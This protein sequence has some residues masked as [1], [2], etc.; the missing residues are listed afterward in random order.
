MQLMF[1]YNSESTRKFMDDF[2]SIVKSDYPITFIEDE[3]LLYM[4][5]K[6]EP[7]F[8]VPAKKTFGN[9]EYIFSFEVK[10]FQNNNIKSYI[11]IGFKK[12]R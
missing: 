2:Y 9:H 1:E 12:Y 6:K 8:K 10:S 3:L 7:C 11:Y 5:R 4:E